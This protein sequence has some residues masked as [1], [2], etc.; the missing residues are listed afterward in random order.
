MEKLANAENVYRISEATGIS[1]DTLYKWGRQ[2]GFPTAHWNR[3]YH[4]ESCEV[5]ECDRLADSLGLCELHYQRL[6]LH[7]STDDPRPTVEERFYVKTT[8]TSEGHLLWTGGTI[9]S[10]SLVYG[11]FCALGETLAH[12]VAYRLFVG[13]I[14]EGYQVDHLC[15]ITLCVWYEHLEAV[16]PEEN[17]RR[18]WERGRAYYQKPG[19]VFK[20]RNRDSKGRFV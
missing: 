16:P 18:V 1:P 2:H 3:R 8:Q 15:S 19:A 9:Q 14:P 17:V 4:G 5:A 7:G 11:Q 10:K 13:E 6:K 20:P 12:R